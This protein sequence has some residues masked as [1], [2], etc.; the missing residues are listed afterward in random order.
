MKRR[1][2]LNLIGTASASA[3][4]PGKASAQ[5][6]RPNI[7]VIMVDDMGF[8]DPGCFGGE[9]DT[10]N[11]NKL[12]DEGI[13]F[14]QFYNTAKCEPSRVTL[15]SGIYHPEVSK[16]KVDEQ[17][18][19]AEVLKTANYNTIMTG[20]WHIKGTPNA[21]GF[22]QYFGHLSG[23]TN[24]F[25]GDKTFRLNED[26][27]DVP[28]EGF[29]T[30]DANVEYANKFLTDIS[31]KDDPFFLYIA[32]NAPHYP[33]H[34]HEKDIKKYKG[35]F[36]EGWDVLRENRYKRQMDMKLFKKKWKLSERTPDAK[37]WN[38]LSD[39]EKKKEAYTME[40][41]AAMIDSVDQNIGKLLD[42]LKKI[43]AYDNTALFFFSDNGGCP[44]QRTTKAT[45]AK[46]LKGDDPK[47]FWTYHY[48][49]ANLSNTPFRWYKQNQHEGGIS[50]GAIAWYPSQI[51][52]KGSISYRMS[53]LVD[54]MATCIGPLFSIR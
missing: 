51:K 30:T 37:A 5:S 48:P 23:A 20:K 16:K 17:M 1:N 31:K 22:D 19:I 41:Y 12:A 4:L 29:Y 42:H 13:R 45:L 52:K 50:S 26:K 7:V 18:T 54:I 53:H 6:L 39:E 24:F 35:R 33:L 28:K 25:W 3:A 27:F 14:T 8:S 38:D 34:A 32:F 2:F 46:D 44:F 43:G 10:P 15:L 21:R 40:V 9:I 36:D 49:W 47:S 11:L